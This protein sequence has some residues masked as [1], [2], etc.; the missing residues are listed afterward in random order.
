MLKCVSEWQVIKGSFTN[1]MAWVMDMPSEE[2]TRP[3]QLLL[4]LCNGDCTRIQLLN[5]LRKT[6]SYHTDMVKP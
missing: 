6:G 2:P 4:T 3:G 5:H 1:I